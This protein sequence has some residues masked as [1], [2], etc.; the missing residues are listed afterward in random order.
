MRIKFLLVSMLLVF[1]SVTYAQPT[2]SLSLYGEGE[3]SFM[4]WTLYSAQLFGK[5]AVYSFDN[6]PIALSL[7]Y[8]RD[9]DKEDLIEATLQQWKHIK[10]NHENRE[11]WINELVDVWPNIKEGDNLTHYIDEQNISTFYYNGNHVGTIKDVD[12]GIAFLSIWLDKNTSEPSLRS[13][14]IGEKQ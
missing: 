4:F 8:Q 2:K 11:L 3:M 5:D 7:T 13:K 9:I 1:C 14:L 6:R 10:L 12:F